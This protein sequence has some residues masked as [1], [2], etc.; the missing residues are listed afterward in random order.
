[1]QSS[2]WI[3]MHI[4]VY[5]EIWKFYTLNLFVRSCIMTVLKDYLRSCHINYENIFATNFSRFTVSRLKQYLT[6]QDDPDG[7]YFELLQSLSR[8]AVLCG[9]EIKP[10]IG[11][12]QV[13]LLTD[14]PEQ[15]RDGDLW[16]YT[17]QCSLI[18]WQLNLD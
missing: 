3:Y 17:N 8:Q 4:S 14:V 11:Q 7:C 5:C 18:T 1:M 10:M 16:A 12:L 9:R 2:P 6:S 15:L 13:P